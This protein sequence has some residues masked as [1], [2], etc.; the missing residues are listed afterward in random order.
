MI[1]LTVQLVS[2]HTQLEA[3]QSQQADSAQQLEI[4]ERRLAES[5]QQ[6]EASLTSQERASEQ[7]EALSAELE[8]SKAALNEVNN[9]LQAAQHK[10][11]EQADLRSAAAAASASLTSQLTCA[12]QQIWELSSRLQDSKATR[13]QLC[14]QLEEAKQELEEVSCAH[15]VDESMMLDHL[16]EVQA[17][18][19]QVTEKW[20]ESQAAQNKLGEQ[21][22]EARCERAEM[23]EAQILTEATLLDQLTDAQTELERSLTQVTCHSIF[24]TIP[25]PQYFY[26]CKVLA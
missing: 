8:P 14:T 23:E 3:S 9:Q 22:A 11:S 12:E 13:P 2:L 5:T 4:A 15:V 1:S 19:R 26:I 6:A 21:L 7:A 25:Q 10:R 16:S 24:T 17:E 20:T 18:P